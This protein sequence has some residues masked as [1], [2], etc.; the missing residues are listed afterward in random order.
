MEFV[1]R[2][3]GVC[4]GLGFP[5]KLTFKLMLEHD[6]EYVPGNGFNQLKLM[7]SG[8]SGVCQGLGKLTEH[9]DED[10]PGNGLT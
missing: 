2:R 5:F 8:R 1:T 9:D 6:D 7:W 4:H 10:V 3:S